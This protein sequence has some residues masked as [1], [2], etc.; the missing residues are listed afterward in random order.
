MYVTWWGRTDPKTVLF[1]VL[2]LLLKWL[3]LDC[4]NLANLMGIIRTT[5]S[6]IFMMLIFWCNKMLL[7]TISFSHEI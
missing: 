6:Q 7:N 1:G 2:I 5:I 3:E 4:Q